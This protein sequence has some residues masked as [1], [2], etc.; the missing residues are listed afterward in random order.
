MSASGTP[1]GIPV[2]VTQTLSDL[3]L[4][5]AHLLEE[6]GPSVVRLRL[7]EARVIELEH[8]ETELQEAIHTS[9]M[10]HSRVK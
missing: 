6:H 9:F 7:W 1:A 8:H 2:S 3:C 10:F 5:H 4:S